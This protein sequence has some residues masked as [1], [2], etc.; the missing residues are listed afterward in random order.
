MISEM[1]TGAETAIVGIENRESN[2]DK[3]VPL[4]SEE[5]FEAYCRTVQSQLAEHALKRKHFL[6]G[7]YTRLTHLLHAARAV[8]DNALYQELWHTR[9]AAR[10]LLNAMPQQ[11]S[12][13]SHD[14]PT[15]PLNTT[16][17]TS[18]A[19]MS[20]RSPSEAALSHSTNGYTPLAMERP[21][22]PRTESSET[23]PYSAPNSY[24]DPLIKMPRRPMRPTEDIEADAKSLREM[25]TTWNEKW[26]LVTEE[27]ILHPVHCLRLRAVACRQRRL[28]E[29]AGDNELS[30]VEE[31]CEE[32]ISLLDAADDQEYTVAFDEEISPPPT[33][34]QWGELAERYEEMAVAQ[35][36]FDWW[37]TN[38]DALT[39]ADIQP[40]AEAVAAVQQRFNR[41]LFR[42]GA[43]DPFQQALFDNLRTWAKEAQCYLHSL[44]PKVPIAELIE[45]AATLEPAYNEACAA[46]TAQR[47]TE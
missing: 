6:Q 46:L 26:P 15:L 42:I 45:R 36:A 28:E 20:P 11:P 4:R 18:N 3:S 5:S 25:L 34:Y 7:A 10:E 38:A 17:F 37:N 33:A 30:E 14:V 22:L 29:E 39:L 19:A 35:E 41:L 21:F 32:I 2:A 8:E 13:P 1:E 12:S 9:A 24:S 16:D 43:R 23:S 47:R 27:G 40:V 44:R 31:L